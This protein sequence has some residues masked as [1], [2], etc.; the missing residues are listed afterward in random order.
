MG[1]DTTVKTAALVAA[2]TSNKLNKTNTLIN[3]GC[4]YGTPSMLHHGDVEI[5]PK[6]Y[7]DEKTK[8]LNKKGQADSVNLYDSNELFRDENMNFVRDKTLLNDEK[9]LDK[10][11]KSN[12]LNMLGTKYLAKCILSKD[13]NKNLIEILAKYVG[14]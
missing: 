2:G 8:V 6:E 3:F 12:T 13:Y 7:I 4:G 1:P 9:I 14:Q 11:F 10:R 5:L